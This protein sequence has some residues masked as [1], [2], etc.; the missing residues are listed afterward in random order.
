[1]TTKPHRHIKLLPHI[2]C[3]LQCLSL[4]SFCVNHSSHSSV[5]C[6]FLL[7]GNSLG[8][9]YGLCQWSSVARRLLASTCTS[10]HLLVFINVYYRPTHILIT[11]IFLKRKIFIHSPAPPSLKS[12]LSAS[13]PRW[14]LT[15]VYRLWSMRLKGF[16]TSVFLQNILQPPPPYEATS[17]SAPPVPAQTP[18]SRTT[19]T[20]PRN[21]GSY[22][23]QVNCTGFDGNTHL[24]V[25]I[26]L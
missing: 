4:Y 2:V 22:N 24:C 13:A 7:L 10:C 12:W 19:P 23:S 17:P 21:Y 3:L 26:R 25:Y 14:R 20:E 11:N 5:A 1:M 15:L 16:L 18:P 6:Q 9:S 8:Q